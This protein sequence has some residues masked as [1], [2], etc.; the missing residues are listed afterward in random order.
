MVRNKGTHM[1]TQDSN[2]LHSEAMTLVNVAISQY[3]NMQP[4]FSDMDPSYNLAKFSLIQSMLHSVVEVGLKSLV[5]GDYRKG[6]SLDSIYGVLFK[7]DRVAADYLNAVFVEA[8]DFYRLCHSQTPSYFQSLKAF[9]EQFGHHDLYTSYRY[10]TLESRAVATV[11]EAFLPRVVELYYEVLRAIATIQVR[12]RYEKEQLLQGVCWR[13]DVKIMHALNRQPLLL[14]EAGDELDKWISLC[15]GQ[16]RYMQGMEDPA[17]TEF[18]IEGLPKMSAILRLMKDNLK[19]DE[20]GAAS[21]WARRLEYLREGSQ[22]APQGLTVKKV[23]VN[24]YITEV[25]DP[26][27]EKLLAWLGQMPDGAWLV[28]M[29]EVPTAAVWTREDAERYIIVQAAVP[30]Y[31]T[32]E[33]Q[34]L[35]TYTVLDNPESQLKG[36]RLSTDDTDEDIFAESSHRYFEFRMWTAHHGI[37]PGER[38]VMQFPSRQY[39]RETHRID[40]RVTDADGS[41]IKISAQYVI[42]FLRCPMEQL[43]P[44]RD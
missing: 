4:D 6:H 22:E 37:Q 32:T 13:V 15:T 5:L 40:G 35:W 26:S 23:P 27:G 33:S 36:T 11:Q 41:L 12:R 31:I 30:V 44:E 3:R 20:D 1:D 34:S 9:L 25:R 2:P 19:H 21:Y 14:R 17:G 28:Y 42:D 39:E 10:W 18:Q 7:K 8:V 29:G 24:R 16:Y 38:I 43:P